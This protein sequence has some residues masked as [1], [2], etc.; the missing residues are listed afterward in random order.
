MADIPNDRTFRNAWV[1]NGGIQ[2]DMPKARDI[3]RNTMRTARKPKLEALDR[4]YIR[5][6]EA[7]DQ[8]E[9]DRIMDD[10]QALR[11]VT[12]DPG[13]EDAKTPE[14]LKDVWPEILNK[15]Q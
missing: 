15:N 1:D 8:V 2:V 12:A 14:T 6:D 13:I 11:D 4:A 5:A 9:K 7:N 3:H 10:K